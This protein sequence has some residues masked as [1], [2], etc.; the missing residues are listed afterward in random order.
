M[1]LPDPATTALSAPMV[2]S[3]APGV[4]PL[5][6]SDAVT[7]RFNDIMNAATPVQ[8]VAH[9]LPT[10]LPI[11]GMTSITEPSGLGNKILAGLQSASSDYS[12]KWR[13]IKTDV[14]E[15]ASHPSA[16]AMLSVQLGVLKASVLYE[17]VGKGIAR[18]TQNIDALVRMS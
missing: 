3:M 10:G 12:K 15:M 2:A 9:P 1:S 8:T 4:G 16:S 17:L 11:S 5:M 18:S 13:S 14:D 6:P 7:Q